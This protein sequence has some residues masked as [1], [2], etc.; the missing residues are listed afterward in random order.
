MR[1]SSARASG[2]YMNP[3]S[4]RLWPGQDAQ[5]PHSPQP[6][7]RCFQLHP[8]SA[9][10]PE[11]LHCGNKQPLPLLHPLR[12]LKNVPVFACTASPR[13]LTL[14]AYSEAAM[15]TSLR[16][17]RRGSAV[18]RT[19]WRKRQ[20]RLRKPRQPISAPLGPKQ[21]KA[22]PFPQH[23]TLRTETER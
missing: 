16:H 11:R 21:R 6:T 23:S 13:R 2:K 14:N 4:W 12:A 1:Q 18:T 22:V 19:A 3:L 8:P 10:A 17:C 20:I 5:S 9:P 15:I 7:A